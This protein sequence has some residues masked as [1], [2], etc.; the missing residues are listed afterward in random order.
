MAIDQRAQ[1]ER[2]RGRMRVH[3][4][5]ITVGRGLPG[6]AEACGTRDQFSHSVPYRS[7]VRNSV[8]IVP[9][10]Q[11]VQIVPRV[12][13]ILMSH[14]SLDRTDSDRALSSRPRRSARVPHRLRRDESIAFVPRRLTGQRLRRVRGL[15]TP[16]ARL[17]LNA[18]Y[19]SL[20]RFATVQPLPF[21]GGI[22]NQLR[23]FMLVGEQGAEV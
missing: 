20:R 15:N 17:S 18:S 2:A 23:K 6:S 4:E 11:T 16:A 13:P 3:R 9:F 19:I 8:Q 1:R 21:S 5:N 12:L 10:D 14:D 7:C 22:Q